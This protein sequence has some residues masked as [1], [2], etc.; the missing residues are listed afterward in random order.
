M[1]ASRSR[2]NCASSRVSP[3]PPGWSAQGKHLELWDEA[4]WNQQREEWMKSEQAVG[5]LAAELG[6]LQL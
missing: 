4:R 1:A 3:A 2:R 5:E 6:T